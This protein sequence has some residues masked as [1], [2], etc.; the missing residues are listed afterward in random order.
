[1]AKTEILQCYLNLDT[2]VLIKCQSTKGQIQ[3]IPVFPLSKILDNGHWSVLDIHVMSSYIR[4]F[5]EFQKY[6]HVEQE[7]DAAI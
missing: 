5:K 7:K 4:V 6:C 3:L 1:M 2:T